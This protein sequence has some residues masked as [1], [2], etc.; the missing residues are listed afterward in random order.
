MTATRGRSRLA[1]RA[2]ATVLALLLAAALGAWAASVTLVRTPPPTQTAP[3]AVVVTVSQASVGRSLTLA[4]VARQ[5][6]VALASNAL[7]GVVTM[8]KPS[9]SFRTGDVLYAVSNTPVRVV[10]GDTPFYRALAPGLT[11]KDVAQLRTALRALGYLDDEGGDAFDAATAE[12]VKAWQAKLGQPATGTIALGEL[13]AVPTLPAALTLDHGVAGKGL[14][15]AGGEKIVSGA[16]GRPDFVMA[17]SADQARLVPASA[18][19]TVTYE[20]HAWKAVQGPAK[21]N[22]DGGVDLPLTAPDGGPVCGRECG[23]LPA[24]D[25]ITLMSNVQ[26]VPEVTGPSV[27]VAA[28][29]TLPDGRV[30]VRAVDAAGVTVDKP[31]TVKG[32]QDGIAVVSGL[33]VGDRVQAMAGKATAPAAAPSPTASR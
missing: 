16:S 8:I 18:P 32:S 24:A 7:A 28:L 13:V 1:I 20:S 27:P 14:A 10:A 6:R 23:V 29:L 25:Q 21:N 9:G 31:V 2:L 3:E 17:L 15:L 11:G 33:A 5:P 26:V 12:A 4:T 30:I 19:I 22:T